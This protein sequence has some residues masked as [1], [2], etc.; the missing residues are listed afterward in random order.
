[1]AYDAEV[2]KTDSPMKSRALLEELGMMSE[3][4]EVSSKMINELENQ[5]AAVLRPARSESAEGY[6]ENQDGPDNAPLTIQ[7]REMRRKI[8]SQHRRINDLLE[9]SEA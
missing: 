2:L 4:I 8:L 3:L 6:P 7:V 5:L 1:M 9:R